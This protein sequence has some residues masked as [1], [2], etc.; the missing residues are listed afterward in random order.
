MLRSP[1]SI[2][3]PFA[4]TARFA[5]VRELGSG[6]MGIVY[7]AVDRVRSSRVALKTLNRLDPT[8]L[9]RFK[10]EFRSLQSLVHPN[11][12]TLYELICEAGQWFFTM[13]LVEGEDFLTYI[14]GGAR[15]GRDET[16]RPSAPASTRTA[17]TTAFDA[18]RS[19]D[20]SSQ[21]V[22][23]P[24]TDEEEIS[25]RS[26]ADPG[27]ERT[28]GP[29]EP[30]DEP[31]DSGRIEPGSIESVDPSCV[32]RPPECSVGIGGRRGIAEG[33]TAE[34][35]VAWAAPGAG[36]PQQEPGCSAGAANPPCDPHR[37]RGVLAQIAEG[38]HHLHESGMLHRDLKPSN[39]LIT[40]DG[41]V[42]ILDFGLVTEAEGRAAPDDREPPEISP[43]G[44]CPTD[45]DL[46]TAPTDRGLVVGTIRYMA[47]EQVEGV[48][49]TRAADWYSFGVMLYEALVG[50]PPFSGDA[51]RILEWKRTTE[52]VPPI[53]RRPGIPPELD[54]LCVR[55]L[56]RRPAERPTFA[57]I[58]AV[59]RPD[60]IA[61]RRPGPVVMCPSGHPFIG[62][63]DELSRLHDARER[64]PEGGPVVV[65]VHGPSGSGKTCLV[66]RFLGR[67]AE[68][69]RDVVLRGRCFEQES[70]PFKAVDSLIDSLSRYLLRQPGRVVSGWLTR[71]IGAS[72]RMFPVLER[73]GPIA[74][75][76]GAQAMP[77][78]PLELRRRAFGALRQLLARI[79]VTHPLVLWIDDLQ[80]GDRDSAEMLSELLRGPDSPHL[81]LLA[82]YRSE[83]GENPC[84]KALTES[85]RSVGGGASVRSLPVGSL[86]PG[87][88]E[89]LAETL[90][91]GSGTGRTGMGSLI[92]RES[93]GHPYLIAEMAR[94]FRED[95]GPPEAGPQ[96][97]SAIGLRHILWSRIRGL[98]EEP[99]RLL[100]I[101]AIAGRPLSQRSAC[102]AVGLDARDQAVLALLRREHLVRST[103]PDIEDQVEVYHDQIRESLLDRLSAGPRCEHHRRLAAVLEA[104]GT[105]DPEMLAVHF[106]GGDQP[107]RAGRYY[108]LAAR[109]AARALAFDRAASLLRRA[110]EVAPWPFPWAGRLKAELGDA[111]ANSR[112][113]REAGRVY[114]E[115]AAKVPPGES[116]ELRRRAFQQLLTAGDHDLGLGELRKVF[117]AVGLPYGETPSRAL[118]SAALGLIRLRV[119]GLGFRR[120]PLYAIAEDELLRLDV[121]WSAGLSLCL[122][123][124]ARAAQVLVH[125]LNRSLR[126]GEALCVA[127]S[128]L[129]VSGLF[130]VR[131]HRGLRRF[132][133]LVRFAGPWVERLD[134]PSLLAVY[135]M[136]RGLAAYA[137]GRW[138]QALECNDRSVAVFRDRCTG[139]AMSLE[140]AAY[141]SLRSL[142]WL[143]DFVGL[144]QRRRA[145]LKEAEERQDL[146]SMTNYRTEVMSYDL[147]AEDDPAAAAGE[148]EEAMSLWSDRG[149]HAQ[150]LFALV[151]RVRV[152][153]YRGRGAA[154]RA[155]IDDAWRAYRASQLH[156]S[157]I[158]RINL[159]YLIACSALAS[160]PG[161]PDLGTLEREASTAADRLDRERIGYASALALMVRGRLASL[162][163]DRM[164][165]IRL[166]RDAVERFRSLSMSFHAAATLDR[167]GELLGTDGGR[168]HRGQAAEWMESQRIRSPDAMI[169]MVLP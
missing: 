56:R 120:R 30:R 75:A 17:T 91:Q 9:Y 45:S 62:R 108:R 127:R 78:D 43:A 98:S 77:P 123:D 4:G 135:H 49:L 132:E 35:G 51:S 145:L 67:L 85:D 100:E 112:R 158:A 69:G 44:R 157:C 94:H 28:G 166:Y 81:L 37:L 154:A 65:V 42:A 8:D 92:A 46:A 47:P 155:A 71:D 11:L 113:G 58:M 139:V 14:R 106:A 79:A 36:R 2:P 105:T 38:L 99:R 61:S 95:P 64:L 48:P 31:P 3:G 10:K 13:E 111:L 126:V 34:A 59:L 163:G 52:P 142:C 66:E 107:E 114:L 96:G 82:S 88:A 54:S 153:L 148:I 16:D 117:Q 115:A 110:L 101:I 169:R 39:V 20:A 23:L 26:F 167:L 83:Y 25:T 80:W 125:N 7:E 68:M 149:F 143:G 116:V 160:W 5:L 21:A 168:E 32:G 104:E 150:H 15:I 97:A 29:D 60:G 50:E 74:S 76:A 93:A 72:A 131:G 124:S 87:D 12:V 24:R 84:L 128:A 18:D 90:L 122:I 22:N 6:G 118:A 63:E 144:R 41:R 73:V 137:Q 130:A 86:T 129:A 161:R 133:E 138:P 146:F 151:G 147:L 162:R 19:E 109:Q 164:R 33:T 27:S 121:G 165:A 152:E 89:R 136:A 40:P 134:D 141:Y 159:D 102:A 53:R 57:E 119:R 140:M 1:E 70:V 103:G 156:R 55:L